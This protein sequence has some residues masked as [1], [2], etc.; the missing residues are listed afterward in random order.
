MKTP[1]VIVTSFRKPQFPQL[2]RDERYLL[3]SILL[4]PVIDK[5]T[6]EGET[7]IPYQFADNSNSLV[8]RKHSGK[9]M[10]KHLYE[11]M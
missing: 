7:A 8:S 9:E 4:N 3:E 2:S 11:P 6:Q 5:R 10:H 1:R